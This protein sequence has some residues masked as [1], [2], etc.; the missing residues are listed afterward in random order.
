MAERP[1]D[2]LQLTDFPDG[3]TEYYLNGK[4]LFGNGDLDLRRSM[5]TVALAANWFVQRVE[6]KD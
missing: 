1:A 2:I 4:F 3:Y 5:E 6:G